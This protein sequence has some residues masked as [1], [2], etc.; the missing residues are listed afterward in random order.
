M[1]L[2]TYGRSTGFC[3]D[4]IEKKPLNHFLPGTPVLSFGTAG[5]NLGCKFCQNWDISKSREVARL[6]DVA[7]PTDIAQAAVGSECRSVAFTYN[8]PVIWAEYAIDTAHE[9]HR[10]GLKTIAV[11]AGYITPQARGEFFQAMDAANID[12]KGFT[13]DFYF[14][15]TGAHLDPVLD[16]IRYVC[17]ETDCWVELTNL[18]I[19]D[20]NDRPDELKRMCEWILEAV[21]PEV[22]V[23][24][25]AFHPDFR[26]NDRP[27]T[28][29]ETLAKAYDLARQAGLRFVYVGNVH[30]VGRQSTYCPGCGQLLIERDWHQIGR[31]ALDGDHCRHCG[32]QIPGH[33]ESQPGTWGRRRQPIRI[34]PSPRNTS[35]SEEA[36]RMP[37]SS[38]SAGVATFSEEEL[39]RIHQ[40]A[41]AQVECAVENRHCDT[42]SLLGDLAERKVAGVY[43]SLKRGETLRGCCGLQGAPVALADALADAATRTAKHDP[44]MT[45]IAAVELPHLTL[46]TSII[47]PPRPIGARGEERV[48]AIAV[49]RHGLRIRMAG[50]AGLLLPSV[51]RD[52][53]WN[54]RQFLDAI[55]TKAGL[56]PGSWL[57]DQANIEIFEGIDHGDHFCCRAPSDP[58]DPE[59]RDARRS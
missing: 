21:G 22:P 16:T 13:E 5:C 44:R 24:F 20:A 10:F 45:P 28:A 48:E 19:P 58:A 1:V 39:N 49:G 25:T 12:L 55:C 51:A 34:A 52:R 14:K 37:V 32:Y 2:D 31:Y 59:R 35:T 11:T 18:L 47:G 53:Q 9:C 54:A 26:M 43:V 57:S 46:S 42:R 40:A 38:E 56:P 27:S 6:S 33:F 36:A 4:P 17:N 15:L 8:D 7:S 30:D 23:H 3:I 50:K 29:P 41:C